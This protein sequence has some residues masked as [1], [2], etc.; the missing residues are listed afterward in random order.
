[1]ILGQDEILKT[2]EEAKI[3]E[4]ESTAFFDA[5]IKAGVQYE[6]QS[7]ED[8]MIADLNYE[9]GREIKL[10]DSVKQYLIQIGK[11]ALLTSKE[12]N[13]F[14]QLIREGKKSKSRSIL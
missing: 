5:F 8:Q 2:M 6:E 13:A 14:A 1:M 9:T 4:T 7:D 3:S 11:I 12:E 10:M